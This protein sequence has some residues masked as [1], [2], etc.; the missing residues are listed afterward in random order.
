MCGCS[1]NGEREKTTKN[2]NQSITDRK[3]VMYT[4]LGVLRG[5]EKYYLSKVIN[6]RCLIISELIGTMLCN[7]T[8]WP[9]CQKYCIKTQSVVRICSSSFFAYYRQMQI[10][11]HCLFQSKQTQRGVKYMFSSIFLPLKQECK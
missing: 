6:S 2:I 8:T 9:T 3:N 7:A 11:N 4:W 10:I 1:V 5:V